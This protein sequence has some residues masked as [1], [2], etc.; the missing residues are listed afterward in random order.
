MCIPLQVQHLALERSLGPEIL[1]VN[2]NHSIT[3]L[4]LT[5]ADKITVSEAYM[6][7]NVEVDNLKAVMDVRTLILPH[8]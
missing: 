5:I 8:R 6:A 2:I 4:S 7:G 3:R 1:G